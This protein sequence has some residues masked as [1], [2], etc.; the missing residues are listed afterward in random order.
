MT[1]G[2]GIVHEEFQSQDF[3]RK[4]GTL[5]MVQLWVNLRAKDKS[6][7]P[8][9]QTLRKAQIRSIALPQGMSSADSHVPSSNETLTPVPADRRRNRRQSL[10]GSRD[11]GI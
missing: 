9:Y 2:K 8:D 11:N 6:A 7:K 3:T 10:A 4:D 5:Q 1:A